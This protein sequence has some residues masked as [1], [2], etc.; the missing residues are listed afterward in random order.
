MFL[1]PIALLQ[2]DQ[3]AVD[4]RTGHSGFFNQVAR[5]CAF[6]V[7]FARDD[8]IEQGARRDIKRGQAVLSLDDREHLIQTAAVL[9][10]FELLQRN[11]YSGGMII[12]TP[13]KMQSLFRS[14]SEW[15]ISE[16][17]ILKRKRRLYVRCG[18]MNFRSTILHPRRFGFMTLNKVSWP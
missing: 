9:L 5:C 8:D 11:L 4:D 10:R 2:R 16:L 1:D 6:V 18:A 17:R 15:I 14:I 12:A 3:F 7:E 13:C